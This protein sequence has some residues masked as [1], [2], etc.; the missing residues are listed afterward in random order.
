MLPELADACCG[1]AILDGG[2]GEDILY[3]GGG[4]NTFNNNDDGELD[5]L[6]VLSD[7]TPITNPPAG[8][9][10]VPMPT[11]SPRLEKKTASRF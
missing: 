2:V 3:G 9:T 4:R 1:D 11:P 7:T 5:L 8:S 6:F 10:T